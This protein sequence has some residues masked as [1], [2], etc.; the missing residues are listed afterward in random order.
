MVL[1]TGGAAAKE[2][3]AGPQCPP[4]LPPIPST[5]VRVETLLDANMHATA[6]VFPADLYAA[7]HEHAA[8]TGDW[9]GI[10]CAQAFSLIRNRTSMSL[11][12]QFNNARGPGLETDM[13]VIARALAR[14]M[15][16]AGFR[17]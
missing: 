4:S 13:T 12:Q 6:C 16:R 9:G 1:G 10:E 11:L 15:E 14:Q 17:L 3:V 5:V 2:P 7:A 8:M